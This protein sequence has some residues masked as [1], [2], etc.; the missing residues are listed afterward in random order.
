[1]GLK[2]LVTPKPSQ[3]GKSNFGG[4]RVSE[5]A[6]PEGCSRAAV[7]KNMFQCFSLRCGIFDAI[8]NAPGRWLWETSATVWECPSCFTLVSKGSIS[9]QSKADPFFR[10]VILLRIPRHVTSEE[11]GTER[12]I[13]MPNIVRLSRCLAS[14]RLNAH[15]PDV[16]RHSLQRPHR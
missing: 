3:L 11:S 9:R 5:G 2:F 1:M 4:W 15:G 7:R 16:V 10:R 6:Y 13:R 12:V 8:L 14:Q